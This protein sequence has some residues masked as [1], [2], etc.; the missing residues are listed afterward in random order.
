[1]LPDLENCLLVGA[2]FTASG[3]VP[4]IVR[5]RIFYLEA[6]CRFALQG[7]TGLFAGSE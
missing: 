3:R 2:I 4:I 7:E 6:L 5:I 1:M